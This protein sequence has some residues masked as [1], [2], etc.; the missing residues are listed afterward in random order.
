M[1]FF[2]FLFGDVFSLCCCLFSDFG[3]CV[4]SFCF[5][6]S[7]YSYGT[8]CGLK[9]G[10]CRSF[11]VNLN[12]ARGRWTLSIPAGSRSNVGLTKPYTLNPETLNP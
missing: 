3:G 1:V 12:V 11:E 5:K 7:M 6:G 9:V 2:S 8:C 4:C 10:L